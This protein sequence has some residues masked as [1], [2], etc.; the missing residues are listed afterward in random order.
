M[1]SIL[2]STRDRFYKSGMINS[3]PPSKGGYEQILPSANRPLSAEHEPK[4]NELADGSRTVGF[5]RSACR[6]HVFPSICRP[7][8]D[9]YQFSVGPAAVDASEG[10]INLRRSILDLEQIYGD[11]PDSERSSQLYYGQPGVQRSRGRLGA[12]LRRAIE[13]D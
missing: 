8:P 10:V 9:I 12:S 3:Q 7:Q 5:T 11:G 2:K 6:V 13:E 1:T 4:L